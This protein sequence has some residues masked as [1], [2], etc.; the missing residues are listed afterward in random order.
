MNL[1]PV[2][3][4]AFAVIETTPVTGP[5]GANHVSEV[6]VAPAGVKLPHVVPSMTRPASPRKMAAL[7]FKEKVCQPALT[8]F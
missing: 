7:I 1:S 6:V 2:G 5:V 4:M 3:G 8:R